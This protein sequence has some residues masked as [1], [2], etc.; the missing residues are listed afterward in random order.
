MTKRSF[1][2]YEALNDAAIHDLE[3]IANR[4]THAPGRDPITPGQWARIRAALATLNEFAKETEH[5]PA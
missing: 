1:N 3:L 4:L 2:L 5:E